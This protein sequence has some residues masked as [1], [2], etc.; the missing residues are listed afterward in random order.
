MEV[1]KHTGCPASQGGFYTEKGD[2]SCVIS[3][4]TCAEDLLK[5]APAVVS[6][7]QE[8]DSAV[9]DGAKTE[10]WRKLRVQAQLCAFLQFGSINSFWAGFPASLSTIYSLMIPR[11]RKISLWRSD[12]LREPFRVFWP[13]KLSVGTPKSN[14]W[15]SMVCQSLSSDCGIVSV[16]GV[17]LCL[18]LPS[19]RSAV[20]IS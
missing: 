14:C 7:V 18:S 4:Y 16:P 17:V 8:L 3:E 2:L 15:A 9:L 20:E 10:K 11:V 13:D 1:S 6:A 12:M 19:C 5:Y